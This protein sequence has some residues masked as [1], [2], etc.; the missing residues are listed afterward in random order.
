MNES[1]KLKKQNS[2]QYD[3]ATEELTEQQE[4]AMKL[5]TPTALYVK[6]KSSFCIK[7]LVRFYLLLRSS[8]FKSK[9]PMLRC[10]LVFPATAWWTTWSQEHYTDRKVKWLTS[11]QF[12]SSFT[13]KRAR[14]KLLLSVKSEKQFMRAH[15][16]LFT[17]SCTPLK[18]Q[19]S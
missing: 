13:Q 7:L 12:C 4:T 1:N 2:Q 14:S 16:S 8:W 3:C 9:C 18:P 19:S 10:S 5:Q 6:E 17:F 11:S 15:S